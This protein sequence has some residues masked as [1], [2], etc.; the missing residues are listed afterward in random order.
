MAV[1][2]LILLFYVKIQNLAILN[3]ALQMLVHRHRPDSLRRTGKQQ[4]ADFQCIETA[5]ICNKLIHCE[6][7]ITGIP[8]LNRPSVNIQM[9]RDL[10]D[11]G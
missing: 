7:H 2:T 9:K 11:I 4:I 1:L 3:I 10:L 8:R 6:E 5:H